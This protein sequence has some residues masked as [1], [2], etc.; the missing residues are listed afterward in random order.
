MNLKKRVFL[1]DNA[2]LPKENATEKIFLNINIS[3]L[4]LEEH[5][6]DKI[7]INRKLD[8]FINIQR[9]IW[10]T[11]NSEVG[12]NKVSVQYDNLES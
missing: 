3:L 7:T 8:F 2:M 5:M 4:K 1:L 10:A 11:I 9:D 6:T 12:L